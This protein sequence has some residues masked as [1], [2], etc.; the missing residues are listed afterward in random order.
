MSPAKIQA[1]DRRSQGSGDVRQQNLVR[2]LE[3]VRDHGPSSRHDIAQGCGL[4]VSTM[5]DLIGELRNRRLLRELGAVPRPGAGRPTRPI[6]MDGQPWCVLAVQVDLVGLRFASSTVGGEELWSE[7]VPAPLRQLGMEAGYAAL[8]DALTA[9][10]D[11][12]PPGKTLVAVQVALPGRVACERGIVGWSDGLGW[13]G[14]P[15]RARLEELL[16]RSGHRGVAVGLAHD[17]HLAALHA[18]RAELAL[19]PAQAVAYLGGLREISGG[20][21]LDGEIYR[22]ADGGAGDFGHVHVD[23]RG[24]LCVC[25][26]HGCLQSLVGPLTLL[27][28]S[29]VLSAEEAPG[30]LD[31]DP[32]PALR[33]LVER[34]DA[35]DEHVLAVLGA[36]GEALGLA[37]DDIIGGLNPHVVVLGGYL[38]MLAPHLL[39]A[40][41]Q[42][43]DLRLSRESFLSTRVVTLGEK[44]PRVLLGALMAARDVCLTNPLRLTDVVLT[45]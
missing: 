12:L 36:A 3:Y 38:G 44:G 42:K 18:V 45:A 15:L 43:V 28:R 40:A 35:G 27:T 24:P 19:P 32:L 16:E 2:I 34:A 33:C 41:Q 13:D 23:P 26:R 14:L 4:G 5:T 1:P 30:V 22:G 9:Q 25:G 11:R 31:R 39:V 6:A 7:D 37:L 29:G 10:L 8:R 17:C 21:V 20:V